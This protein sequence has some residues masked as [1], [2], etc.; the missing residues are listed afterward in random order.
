MQTGVVVLRADRIQGEPLLVDAQLLW[1]LA[2][3]VLHL[4]LQGQVAGVWC[5]GLLVGLNSLK[6]SLLYQLVAIL[7]EFNVV[8]LML[9]HLLVV[10]AL[11]DSTCKLHLMLQGHVLLLQ[12]VLIGRLVE[13]SWSLQLGISLRSV[14]DKLFAQP[15]VLKVL[16]FADEGALE[17]LR[18]GYG[19]SL[20]VFSGVFGL[21]N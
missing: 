14:V 16:W 1:V 18:M 7:S 11:S 20:R 3:E 17:H 5:H 10:G 21:W 2:V 8:K 15:L 12:E 9:S 13:A 19:F 4:H 6:E